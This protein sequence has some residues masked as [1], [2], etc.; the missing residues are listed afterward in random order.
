MHVWTSHGAR[1]WLLPAI[2]AG[3]A[4][5][6]SADPPSTRYCEIVMDFS[7][8]GKA[9]AAPSTIVE[10]GKEAEITV[11]N[12]DEHA[13]RFTIVA[14]EPAI[15][16][17]V[18]VIPVSVDL[19]EIAEGKAFLRAS[20]HFNATPG[21]RADIETIFGDEDGRK[22]RIALVANLRSDADVQ[23]LSPDEEPH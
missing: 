6:A 13:W 9:V 7:V 10:F 3:V 8:N 5:L 23:A 20:P 18:G 1:R 21:Q 22:A 15:V 4:T 16:H 17:R 11:G 19:Y 14:D 2:L 12:P